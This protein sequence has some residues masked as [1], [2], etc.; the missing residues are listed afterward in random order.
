MLFLSFDCANKTL[1]YMIVEI[2][3]NIIE[4]IRGEVR[5]EGKEYIKKK[6]KIK[7]IEKK[8][9]KYIE[10]KKYGVVDVLNGKK[11]KNT[12]T[13]ERTKMLKNKLDELNFLNCIDSNTTIVIEKQPRLSN[14]K[15]STICD[16]IM[17][18]FADYNIN[19]ISPKLKNKIS[20][21]EKLRHEIFLRKY[22]TKYSADK[23]HSKSNFLYL[24]KIF[25][26]ES[27]LSKI[28][29]SSYDD[30]ADSFQQIIAYIVFIL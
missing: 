18:Y 15:S 20:Y 19:L 23:N 9:E 27:I 21:N 12:T 4:E 30:I 26:Q 13:I 14:F 29:K 22:K 5:N 8:L 25:K 17:M 11:I 2:N 7:E 24:L 3:V 28:Q 16:Q 10:F 6:Q 1:A